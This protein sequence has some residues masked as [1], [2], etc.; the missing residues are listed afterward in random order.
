MFDPDLS[1]VMAFDEKRA[2]CSSCQDYPE[3]IQALKNVRMFKAV[4]DCHIDCLKAAIEVGANV[5]DYEELSGDRMA[6]LLDSFQLER[7]DDCSYTLKYL[8]KE[9]GDVTKSPQKTAL[10]YAVEN[11][12]LE[13]AELLIEPGADADKKDTFGRTA[14][15]M[16][17]ENIWLE[18]VEL[19]IG[20]GTNVDEKDSFYRTAL[21]R[22]AEN[23]NH[24]LVNVLIQAGAD[25]NIIEQ[26]DYLSSSGRTALMYA[27][28]S[29]NVQCVESL[30]KSGA[31]V[32]VVFEFAF[33]AL[34]YA[35]DSGS[36][37]IL[38]LL[39][40]AGARIGIAWEQR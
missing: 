20:S 36:R 31:D 4:S 19:L 28:K 38:H 17:V 34:T 14:L 24:Q 25:L 2:M 26:E 9:G 18:G 23:G 6:I 15:M 11:S 37:E 29:G 27:A 12:W 22:A 35:A 10:L 33:T 40:N 8:S 32:N 5:N 39:I 7:F 1:P 16:A 21:T 30:L 3:T 13:G